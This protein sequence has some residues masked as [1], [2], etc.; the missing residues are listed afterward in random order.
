MLHDLIKN[1]SLSLL[2][3]F[4]IISTHPLRLSS[5]GLSMKFSLTIPGHSDFSTLSS[6]VFI[7][8]TI[9]LAPKICCPDC[10]LS[11]Y[12]NHVVLSPTEP[13]WSAKVCW[14]DFKFKAIILWA[15]INSTC[16]AIVNSIVKV[17]SKTACKWVVM[18]SK[19]TNECNSSR[20]QCVCVMGHR[21]ATSGLVTWHVI[22]M[23]SSSSE[24]I[25]RKPVP[26]NL[27]QLKHWYL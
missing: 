18:Q 1:T 21:C 11:F 24:L 22:Y 17:N 25:L 19:M 5:R 2:H 23:N 10:Y 14:F 20:L 16:K 8:W 9:H 26:R 6:M 3:R 4:H 13:C 12:V 15:E 7:I 27:F